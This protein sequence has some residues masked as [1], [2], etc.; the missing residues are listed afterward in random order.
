MCW[1][2]EPRREADERLAAGEP[3]RG[4]YFCGCDVGRRQLPHDWQAAGT[5]RVRPCRRQGARCR[6]GARE[7][8]LAKSRAFARDASPGN[9]KQ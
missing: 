3:V 4:G 5:P 1:A 7:A 9:K 8:K 2:G 6:A